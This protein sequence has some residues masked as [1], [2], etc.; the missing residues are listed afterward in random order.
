MNTDLKNIKWGAVIMAAYAAGQTQYSVLVN[1]GADNKVAIAAAI[2]A[3]LTAGIACVYNSQAGSPTTPP[4]QEGDLPPG[5]D[6][7]GPAHDVS[8]EVVTATVSAV[9]GPVV[10]S[11]APELAGNIT[12]E[13]GRVLKRGIRF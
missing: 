5:A 10:A 3:A 2:G 9:L 8:A 7:T 6:A 11:T 4:V 1:S 12:K 13:I